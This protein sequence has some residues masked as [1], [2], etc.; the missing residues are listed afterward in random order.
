MQLEMWQIIVLSVYSGISM[1]D[2][3]SFGLGFNGIIQSGI[4]AGLVVGDVE[5]GLKVGG[6]LQSYAL[7]IGTY[8]GSSIPNYSVAAILVTA[9]AGGMEKAEYYITLIGIPIAS[10]TLQFDI[11]GRFTNTIFQHMADKYIETANFKKI[12]LMN[13]LG[14]IPWSLS[15]AVPVFF[16]LALGGEFVD[17]FTS[18]IPAWL[19]TGFIIAGKLLPAVGFTILLKYL[20]TRKNLPFLIIG[21]VLA[22]YLAM[23][24]L[25]IA[26]IGLAAALIVFKQRT[27]MM[28][29]TSMSGGIDD[30][31]YDE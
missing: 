10:L 22:A 2:A 19:T 15:R 4:V 18:S 17:N 31:E 7:G 14:C 13:L 1:I 16:A 6:V 3:L 12:E 20:P 8:G 9:L 21:F 29:I 30:D 26:L 27:Q 28:A 24:T 5:T 23:D 25:S 11:L